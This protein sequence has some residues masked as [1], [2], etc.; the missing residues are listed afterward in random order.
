MRLHPGGALTHWGLNYPD[1]PALTIGNVT[2][3]FGEINSDADK[4]VRI[5]RQKK[6]SPGDFI[7]II[8]PSS[9][10]FIEVLYACLKT[11]ITAIPF[12]FSLPPTHLVTKINH[13]NC[14]LLV[15][16]PEYE[17]MDEL[18]GLC[19]EFLPTESI[20][21]W[22]GKH[23]HAV[24]FED[25]NFTQPL[26]RPFRGEGIGL[27]DVLGI[28]YTSGTTGEPKGIVKSYYQVIS[29][30]I[31]WITEL[32]L[33]FGD[34]MLLPIPF[35]YTGGFLI[36]LSSMFIGAH[37]IVQD[38]FDVKNWLDA[39][40][41]FNVTHAYLIPMHTKSLLR[42]DEVRFL[43]GSSLRLIVTSSDTTKGDQK[44]ELANRFGCKVIDIWGNTEGVGTITKPHD[45]GIRPDSI[46]KPFLTDEVI[47]VDE[48]MNE[49]EPGEIGEIIGKTD[50]TF[51][52]YYLRPD[53]TAQSIH[54][55]WIF[56]GDLGWKDEEGYFYFAGRK[57]DVIK[58]G[59]ASIY[60]KDLER[61][62]ENHSEVHEAVVFS[63]EQENGDEKLV[64]A[65]LLCA[66]ARIKPQ[67]LLDWANKKL[68]K[69]Q[70]MYDLII[71]DE[72]PRT[73]AGKV[74]KQRLIEKYLEEKD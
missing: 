3:S 40:E 72:F 67:D 33:T 57:K 69:N 35:Y 62:L 9:F 14:H 16:H 12:D 44:I 43:E 21:T 23:K 45:L 50:S 4:A 51:I 52:E 18:V 42:S 41:C 55:G 54:D 38:Q 73:S 71:C 6:C 36:L 24:Y 39:L 48:S 22:K 34:I 17:K 60:P 37:L 8:C 31:V 59:G 19:N 56:S 63:V 58:I 47:I 27:N 64:A 70:F 61:I 11:G 74:I 65:V 13:S 46:G 25:F 30:L 26:A 28:L 29:E 32:N 66:G 68:S 5:F 53:L 1:Q 15:I 49:V 20:L 7:G 2:R 10:E